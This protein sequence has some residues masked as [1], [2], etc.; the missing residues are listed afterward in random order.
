MK[1][2]YGRHF[3]TITPQFQRIPE[4]EQIR[5][6]AGG[7]AFPVTDEVQATRFLVMGSSEST[8]YASA[9]E[10]TREAATCIDRLLESGKGPWLVG[11]I[12]SISE[13]GRAPKNDP[14]ILALAM[15]LKLGDLTTKRMA[16]EFMPRVCRTATHMAQFAEAVKLFSK[17]TGWSRVTKRAFTNWL[18][19]KTT[20]QLAYQ[21]VKYRQREGW[22]MRDVLRKAKP[23]PTSMDRETVYGWAAGKGSGVRAHPAILDAFEAAQKATTATELVRLIRDHNLPWEAVPSQWARDLNVQD[24][25]FQTMPITATIRQLG[26]LTDIGLLAPTSAAT[27]LAIKRITDLHLLRRG[28]VHP[29]SLYIAEE[30]YAVG[31]G[32]RGHS[33]WTPVPALVE[34]LGQAYFMATDLQQPTNKNIVVGVDISQSMSHGGVM[35][36]P[37]F[38]LHEAALMS[39]ALILRN[40]PNTRGV[41]FDTKPREFN[42]RGI[43]TLRE[44]KV[45]ARQLINNGGGTDCSVP[46]VYA[47][48]HWPD[49]DAFVIFTD[50]ETWRGNI[51]PVEANWQYRQ[52]WGRPT[53]LITQA[54]VPHSYG[55]APT[56]G[57][58]ALFLDIAGLDEAGPQ[59]IS[60]FLMR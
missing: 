10:L 29:M 51:H 49:V 50:H 23:H 20:D 11:E 57:D 26:R 56:E 36:L 9:R 33:S 7:W 48:Q 31:R 46:I 4:S 43:E 59:I 6:R 2:R 17:G 45:H 28:R 12:V 15:C 41:L 38:M 22:T 21:M 27:R 42:L 52:K 5:N 54:F 39:A 8:Y 58:D 14:A 44:L 53:K 3:G 19:S 55:I 34:A 1:Q 24:A 37:S 16:A 35:G 40:E 25:L 30:V 18:D 13:S 60:E 32:I 47:H